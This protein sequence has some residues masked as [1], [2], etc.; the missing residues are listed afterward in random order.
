MTF[1]PDST[2]VREMRT[3]NPAAEVTPQNLIDHLERDRNRL[4]LALTA[5]EGERNRAREIADGLAPALR[6]CADDSKDLLAARAPQPVWVAANITLAEAALDLHED[7]D[8]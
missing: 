7:K 8:W 5:A 3:A 6:R 1:A 4:R 2:L